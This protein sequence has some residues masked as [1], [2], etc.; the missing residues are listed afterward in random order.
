MFSQ[1][2]SRRKPARRGAG[3]NGRR[4]SLET[5]EDRLLLYSPTGQTWTSPDLSFSYVPDGSAWMGN[6]SALFAALD[7]VAP[8]D[9][10]QREFARALQT[11]ANQ[12]NLNFHLSPDDGSRDGVQG[13]IRLAAVEHN[14]GIA[15]AWGPTWSVTGGDITLNVKYAH[16][17][18]EQVDLYSVLLHESG[19]SLGLDHSQAEG[20]IMRA[21]IV[22]GG[23]SPE[24]IAAIQSLYGV[25]QDD[26]FDQVSRNDDFASATDLAFEGQ[27]TAVWRADLTSYADVDYYRITIPDDVD[28]LS[29][30]V[31][32]R[33]LS[34]LAPKVAVY[35]QFHNLVATASGDYGTV[36]AVDIAVAPG[37]TYTV[38]ADGATSDEFG[39][40]AYRLN[41]ALARDETQPPTTS[42]VVSPPTMP[43]E[44][45]D[46]PPSDDAAAVI[47]PEPTVPETIVNT[48]D[49]PPASVPA[50]PDPSST[51]PP[52]ANDDTTPET[53]AQ[54]AG[55]SPTAP[56]TITV[57]RVTRRLTLASQVAAPSSGSVAAGAQVDE[58]SSEPT[59]SDDAIADLAS[60]L[61]SAVG[62]VGDTPAA[63]QS[64][65]SSASQDAH[66][67]DALAETPQSNPAR[68]DDRP[69]EP[70]NEP[71]AG[72][73]CEDEDTLPAALPPAASDAA[74]AQIHGNFRLI[75]LVRALRGT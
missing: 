16:A 53:D 56:P 1:R 10:W 33:E 50:T 3:R 5:L 25:R 15:C 11:W 34:L 7:D 17:F 31:D 51:P 28:V 46:T 22:A 60:V 18:F 9:V 63:N 68:L 61:A 6:T 52:I 64:A 32:A 41:L 27:D 57:I 40:G 71:G 49:P 62:T 73:G 55:Q 69:T 37:Q 65:S 42:I 45:P 24:D 26:A 13:D 19:H 29:V 48:E 39:M 2:R 4:L 54:P 72:A 35:D 12:T 8:R 70:K 67:V 14:I 44:L 47:P 43:T 23:L 59:G 74:M 38:V 20:S 75:R 36:A 66:S 30:A 58:G 21:C